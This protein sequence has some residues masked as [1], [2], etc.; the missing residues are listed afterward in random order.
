M[1]FTEDPQEKLTKTFH[2]A[3]VRSLEIRGQVEFELASGPEPLVTVETSR[4]LFDQ[5]NV[6]NWWGSATIA[7]ESGFEVPANK[8]PS[9]LPLF[10][11]SLEELTVSDH[12]SGDNCLARGPKEP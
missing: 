7:I 3:Q 2:L 4:A 6:S 12:S 9:R 1:G 5:L 8:G 10:L 11:P